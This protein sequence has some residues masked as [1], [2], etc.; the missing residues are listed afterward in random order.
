[1]DNYGIL[2]LAPAAI[3][4]ILAF[5]TRDALLSILIGVLVGIVIDG[6]N[7]VTGFTGLIQEALGNADFIWVLGIEVFIGIMVAFFQ[8]SGAIRAFADWIGKYNLKAK[9][10]TFLS[11]AL[12]IFIFFS[13][14]FSPL[15][16]GNVMR[17][18]T[19]K[20]RVSREMLAYI[21]DS[22][23]AP[24]CCLIPFTSWGIYVAGLLVG[25]G[26]ITDANISQSVVIHSAPFNFYCIFALVLCGLLSA[27]V[28]PHF[29]PMKKAQ[30]RAMDEGKVIADGANPLLSKELDNIM[31][32]EGIKP[33][34]LVNFLMPAVIIIGIT[35]G[36]YVITGSALTL[37]AF[38]VAVAYQFVTL[39]VQ[40][41][42]NLKEIMDTA[43]EGIKSVMSAIL[44][45]AMAYCINHISGVLGTADYVI[46]VTESWMTPVTLLVVTFLICAFI[47]FF[48]G[49]SWG[50]FAI[51]IPIAIP[52]AFNVSGG[53][54]NTVVYA[55]VGA[56]MGGGTF[57]DHCSPLSD[58]TILS[59]L[60]SGSDH[61]DHVKTQMP[62]AITAAV[63]ACIGFLIVGLTL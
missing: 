35:V 40:K 38:V 17:P 22:T 47:S 55:A 25:I 18:I 56:V 62:Y 34:L 5:V 48:T 21:C 39:L 37:E 31:P 57:G 45:L 13:D 7:I 3:A 14:Y 9:G 46:S 20:A 10:A 24:I 43:I 1:M 54:L 12:G 6:Q 2:S 50:V 8:K 60:A 58:T 27:G 51:M 49:T 53:E 16:V 19:D 23:S 15:Y 28:I 29:G 4:L 61:V 30:K 44:I 59:S 52:L 41:M 11:F 32:K 26:A 36:T 42:A 33:N 63:I